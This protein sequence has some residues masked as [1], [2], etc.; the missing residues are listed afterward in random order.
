MGYHIVRPYFNF[1]GYTGNTDRH[2]R[3]IVQ[4][5]PGAAK[6]VKTEDCD[7]LRKNFRIWK[8][9]LKRPLKNLIIVSSRH[10]KNIREALVDISLP[11]MSSTCG[12]FFLWIRP[13]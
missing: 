10:C 3:K 7:V 11:Q 6:L 8:N 13:L 2:Q 4:N 5:E 1:H 9:D 12:V